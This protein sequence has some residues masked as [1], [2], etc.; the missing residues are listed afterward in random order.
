MNCTDVVAPFLYLFSNDPGIPSLLY[1]THIPVAIITIILG[2]FI[3]KNKFSPC[4][5]GT[6]NKSYRKKMFFDVGGYGSIDNFQEDLE[7]HRKLKNFKK[8]QNQNQRDFIYGFSTSNYHLSSQPKEL[9]IQKIAYDQL[10]NLN[11]L[12]KKFNIIPDYDGYNKY[13]LLDEIFKQ[14]GE[15]IDIEVLPNGDIKIP[16]MN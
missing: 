4:D 15:S 16:N 10:V 13:I 9:Q 3:Y 1:Y 11:S 7:L 8:D 2:I 12:N 14:K 6:N 5:G